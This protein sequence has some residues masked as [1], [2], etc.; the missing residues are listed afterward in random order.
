[1]CNGRGIGRYIVEARKK[2]GM[3]QKQLSEKAGVI[4]PDII[5]IEDGKASV[6][7]EVIRI[8]DVLEIPYFKLLVNKKQR[9]HRP[10]CNVDDCKDLYV[11]VDKAYRRIFNIISAL[12]IL[13][14]S[15]EH[16]KQ[17]LI[18][19]YGESIVEIYNKIY[20]ILMEAKKEYKMLDDLL[21]G[22]DYDDDEYCEY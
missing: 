21:Y 11:D 1:M 3:S 18:Y 15:K 17:E 14:D 10:K 22:G 20:K 6:M 12:D 5:E 4:L 9:R 19:A 2:K 7:E 13:D 8:A 16:Y